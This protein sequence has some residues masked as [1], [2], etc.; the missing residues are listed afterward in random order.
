M[1]LVKKI[2]VDNLLNCILVKENL[3]PAMLIQPQ[4]YG[5]A[6]SSDRKTESIIKAIKQ[7]FPSFLF[8]E[9]YNIYQGIIISKTDYNGQQISL[10]DMGKILGYPCY[11]DFVHINPADLSYGMKIYVKEKNGNQTDIYA[12]M[13]KDK[14][15]IS[16]FE[17]FVNEIKKAIDKNKDLLN[18]LEI[19]EI[20]LKVNEIVP[21]QIIINHLIEN[22]I[23]TDNELAKIE[24]ILDNFG[25]SDE[26]INYFSNNFEYNNPVHKGILLNLL[27]TE[28]HDILSPFIPLQNYPEQQKEVDE[29]TKGLEKAIIEILEKTKKNEYQDL[30]KMLPHMFPETNGFGKSSLDADIR[31][32]RGL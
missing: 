2:G 28:K 8:S 11:Q 12:N 14:S 1:S 25:F 15:N 6:S 32:L 3:R 21:T 10:E 22:K 16:K 19:E 30:T 18:G 27:V 20:Y 13:C 4:D 7:N 29:I 24:D 31:Y 9:H 5:E 26:T 23:L 17:K